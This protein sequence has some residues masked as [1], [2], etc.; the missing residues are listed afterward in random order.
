MNAK[1]HI[2]HASL[3][4]NH[5]VNIVVPLDVYMC[6][7]IMLS[8]QEQTYIYIAHYICLSEIVSTHDAHK[9]GDQ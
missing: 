2:M 1:N 9:R 4:F 5:N 6:G 8:T 7:Q 3:Q